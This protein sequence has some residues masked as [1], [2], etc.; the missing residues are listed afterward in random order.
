[1]TKP[2]AAWPNHTSSTNTHDKQHEYL[3]GVDS[4]LEHLRRGGGH[5]VL[6][7][8]ALVRSVVQVLVDRVRRLSKPTYPLHI[9]SFSKGGEGTEKRGTRGGEGGG[10]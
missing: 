6:Q 1:M 4:H 2:Q 9:T 10:A 7:D 8:A 3:E 5:G